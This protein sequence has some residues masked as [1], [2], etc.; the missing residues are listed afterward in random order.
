E[1]HSPTL[2]IQRDALGKLSVAGM[3]VTGQKNGGS[4]ADWLI[5]QRKIDIRDATIVWRDEMRRAPPLELKNVRVQIINRGGSHQFALRA[6]PPETLAGPL[7]VRGDL[8]GTTVT[9]VDDWNGRLFLDLD[10]ADIAAWRPWVPFPV[11]F[12]RGTGG[13]RT[14]LTF[15]RDRL[16][17]A[18]VDLKLANVRT[19]LEKNL[20]ELEVTE[21]SGRLGWKMSASGFEV[22]TTALK[23]TTA[24]GLAL[25]PIDFLLRFNAASS[26]QPERGEIAVNVLDFAP[27]VALADHLPF[28]AEARKQLAEHAPKGQLQDVQ[29]RWSGDWRNPAQYS[30]KGRFA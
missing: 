4:F 10:Y 2:N 28:P 15:S 11:E 23:L 8:T 6:V 22:T 30:A 7:D 1:I 13:L 14:W 5:N 12:P 17:D 16:T 9:A 26:S 3:E 19:R 21:L 27:L 24:G 29:V 18:L 25:P 20:P